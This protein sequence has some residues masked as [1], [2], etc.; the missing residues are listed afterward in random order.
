MEVIL[1]QRKEDGEEH[2]VKFNIN[3]TSTDSL[4]ILKSKF[5]SKD[6]EEK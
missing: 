1:I 6:G 2:Y 5:G 4:T 3:S